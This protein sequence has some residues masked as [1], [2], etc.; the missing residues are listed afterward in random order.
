MMV[1]PCATCS[2]VVDLT[3]VKYYTA[4]QQYVF[5]DAYCSNAWYSKTFEKLD[6]KKDQTENNNE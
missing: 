1:M 5:C 2:K 4:D 3:S 6:A